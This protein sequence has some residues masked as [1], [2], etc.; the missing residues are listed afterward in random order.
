MKLKIKDIKW[1]LDN[2][3]MGLY[4]EGRYKDCIIGSYFKLHEGHQCDC[5]NGKCD[6]KVVLTFY[7]KPF[8]DYIIIEYDL[9]EINLNDDFFRMKIVDFYNNKNLI[10]EILKSDIYYNEIEHKVIKLNV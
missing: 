7:F 3:W 8:K 2:D 9:N 10:K 1:K 5:N 4:V 6:N